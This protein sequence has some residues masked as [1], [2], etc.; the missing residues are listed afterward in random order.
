MYKWKWVIVNVINFKVYFSLLKY[1]V[2]EKKSLLKK[3][4]YNK[5]IIIN[6]SKTF[7]KIQL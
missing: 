6:G 4:N 7:Q 5:K 1:V 3:K 2:K